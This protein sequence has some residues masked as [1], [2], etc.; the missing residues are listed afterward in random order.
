MCL[1]REKQLPWWS[2]TEH[3]ERQ[4]GNLIFTTKIAR[5]A[6]AKARLVILA[7]LAVNLPVKLNVISLT[8]APSFQPI[9]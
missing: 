5:H 3:A 4:E 9:A 1:C 2:S 8:A 6:K 7:F